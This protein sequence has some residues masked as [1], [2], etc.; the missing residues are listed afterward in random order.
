MNFLNSDDFQGIYRKSLNSF[1]SKSSFESCML[2]KLTLLLR[3]SIENIT[4]EFWKSSHK[5][6][7]M[8]RPN[9]RKLISYAPK[10][11]GNKIGSI[12]EI[13]VSQNSTNCIS[14]NLQGWFTIVWCTY[15]P[16]LTLIWW[17]GG[18]LSLS[19]SR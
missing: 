4:T 14:W 3:N 1:H 7:E 15:W 18:I 19:R 9:T 6:F 2:L 5:I 16:N 11:S 8:V 17:S 13:K 12:G 10:M